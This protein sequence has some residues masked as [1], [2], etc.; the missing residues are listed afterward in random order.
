MTWATPNNRVF[1]RLILHAYWKTGPYNNSAFD[2]KMENINLV[3]KEYLLKYRLLTMKSS[4]LNR[5][6]LFS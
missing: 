5:A 6:C 3:C 4:N 1:L 2:I